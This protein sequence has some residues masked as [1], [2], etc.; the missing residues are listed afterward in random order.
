MQAL[1]LHLDMGAHILLAPPCHLCDESESVKMRRLFDLAGEAAFVAGQIVP[2]Q[3]GLI[4]AG[5]SLSYDDYYQMILKEAR[6]LEKEAVSMIFM[7]DFP[8]VLSAKC[9]LYAIRE[10]STLPVCAGFKLDA[11]EQS[12]KKA[13]SLLVTLQALDVSAV[14]VT[15]MD[16]EDSLA[17][18][19][20]MQAF[21]TVPLFSICEAS[22]FVTPE[23]YG[24]YISSFVNQKCAIVGLLDKS[25]AYTASAMKATWQ[26][27][28]LAPDFPLLNA[29][30]SCDETM[31]LDFSGHVVSR[32][33]PL[34]EIKSEELSEVKQALMLFNK[35]GVAPVSFNIKDIDVLRHAIM[36]YAGRP[37]V[38]SDEY[39]E[40]L[41]RELGAFVLTEETKET[42]DK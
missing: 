14:G 33:K 25:A 23:D 2:P 9:A 11:E 18:L 15:G 40:I 28:P 8:D 21:A 17:L 10:G 4:E 32:Q 26:L 7:T 34:I 37:A 20:E 12:I 29:V 19:A 13:L 6:F 38:R 22:E 41:A 30:S 36:H 27:S 35:L 39:G 5:G 42:D 24:D 3:E 1:E 16:I 31:F